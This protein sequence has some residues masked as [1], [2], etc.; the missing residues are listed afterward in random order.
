MPLLSAGS[1][2]AASSF[3]YSSLVTRHSSLVTR[4]SSLVTCHCLQ[5]RP[6]GGEDAL[7]RFGQGGR[8]QDGARGEAVAAAAE[9]AGDAGD[10]DPGARAEADLDAAGGLLQ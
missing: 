9:L 1:N 2:M 8:R 7:A 5:R 6:H 4:H 10:I 3:L